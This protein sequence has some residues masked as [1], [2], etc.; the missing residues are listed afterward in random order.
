MS[1]INYS[2]RRNSL[3]NSGEK[4]HLCVDALKHANQDTRHAAIA[5]RLIDRAHTVSDRAS[6]LHR[7]LRRTEPALEATEVLRAMHAHAQVATNIRVDRARAAKQTRRREL[8]LRVLARR[9]QERRGQLR[10][11]LEQLLAQARLELRERGEVLGRREEVVDE[12]LRA[13]ARGLLHARRRVHTRRGVVCGPDCAADVLPEDFLLGALEVRV[14]RLDN[15]RD[16]GG[17]SGLEL[18]LERTEVDSLA[19]KVEVGGDEDLEDVERL[20]GVTCGDEC[21]GAIFI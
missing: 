13:R 21:E 14:V 9:L 4:R 8:E 11:P 10:V 2:S 15:A 5:N 16:G 6:S 17:D 20:L 3:R 1:A 7:R 18:V 19:E 12:R